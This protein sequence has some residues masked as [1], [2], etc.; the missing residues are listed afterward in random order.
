M[1]LGELFSKVKE[2]TGPSD[3]F[4]IRH[5]ATLEVQIKFMVERIDEL[6]AM[7]SKALSEMARLAKVNAQLMA[8]LTIKEIEGRKNDE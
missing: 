3:Q 2:P 4:L 5:L 8:E 7:Y 1:K 6:S